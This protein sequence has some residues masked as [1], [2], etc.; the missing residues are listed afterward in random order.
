MESASLW[1]SLPAP[2]ESDKLRTMEDLDQS[3]GYILYRAELPAETGSELVI[4]GLHDYAQIYVE[5]KLIGTLDR[6]LG[7]SRLALPKAPGAATLDILW[8]TRGA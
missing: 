3:Y 8:R 2:V 1:N 4:D 6:R 5:R 7:Q